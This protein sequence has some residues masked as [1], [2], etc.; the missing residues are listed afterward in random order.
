MFCILLCDCRKVLYL[1]MLTKYWW[2]W[3]AKFG[4][5]CISINNIHTKRLCQKI[6]DSILLF[7]DRKSFC[8]SLNTFPKW[9]RKFFHSRLCK[10]SYRR[11]L[12]MSKV[13]NNK[14]YNY[15]FETTVFTFVLLMILNLDDLYHSLCEMFKGCWFSD[16]FMATYLPEQKWCFRFYNKR[17]G[18]EW[19][20]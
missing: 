2:T 11:E 17:G 18:M 15:I 4:V 7:V 10:R 16:L 8:F 13:K 6:A 5:L 1:T 9:N 3:F 19:F 12:M 20:S 14:N